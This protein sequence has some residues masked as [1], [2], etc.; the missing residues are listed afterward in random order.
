MPSSKDWP[1]I[2]SAICARTSPHI[3]VALAP[4]G[5]GYLQDKA[6]YDAPYPTAEKSAELSDAP[7]GTESPQWSTVAE[8]APHQAIPCPAADCTPDVDEQLA[9]L[10]APTD[11]HLGLRAGVPIPLATATAD[12]LALVGDGAHACAR[13]LLVAAI[14]AGGPGPLRRAAVVY[15]AKHVSTHLLGAA[16]PEPDPDRF[17][18]VADMK[19]LLDLL[20][21]DLAERE[22]V[23]ADHEYADA[24]QL[25]RFLQA[26]AIWPVIVLEGTMN[27]GWQMPSPADV[28]STFTSSRSASRRS[29]PWRT[30][31]PPD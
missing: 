12:G 13:A 20:E 18:P 15:T 24:A 2:S 10:D 23:L 22:T 16:C 25:R 29:A 30:S 9:V 28:A 5:V 8:P 6:D 31:T 1:S 17:T 14:A 26:A 27:R 3:T 21:L 11:F 4:P 19:S 7:A